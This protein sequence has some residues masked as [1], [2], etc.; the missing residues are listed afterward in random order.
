VFGDTLIHFY[1]CEIKFKR[2]TI[3]SRKLNR[4][5]QAS[6]LK[7]ITSMVKKE[8]PWAKHVKLSEI[9]GIGS[10]IWR[11]VNIDNYIDN[12]RQW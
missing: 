10:S 5:E 3:T 11:D 2:N 6:L 4:V 7:K 9:S 12:E 1:E 8:N